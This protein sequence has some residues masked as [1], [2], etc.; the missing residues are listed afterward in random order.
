MNDGVIEQIGTP[1]EIYAQPKTSFVANFIGS[2]N[3]VP[4]TVVSHDRVKAGDMS[5]ECETDGVAIGTSIVMA[6]R[7]ED[8]NAQDIREG[9]GNVIDVSI[10]HLEF[11]GSF[12]RAHL[13]SPAFSGHDV[14]A[15]FSVNLVRRKSL[16][17]GSRLPV[18]FPPELIRVYPG[19]EA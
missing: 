1:E 3:F 17:V 15:D 10:N 16:E 8:I 9:D 18:R 12:Y 7:T 5:L 4:G 19:D 6:I 14:N 2:T 13:D 11:L